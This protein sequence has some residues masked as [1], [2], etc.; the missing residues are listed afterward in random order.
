MIDLELLVY[1]LSIQTLSRSNRETKSNENISEVAIRAVCVLKSRRKLFL[2]PLN[3]RIIISS[4]LRLQRWWGFLPTWMEFLRDVDGN[5]WILFWE[6]LEILLRSFF[7]CCCEE[8]LLLK[9]LAGWKFRRLRETFPRKRN[10]SRQSERKLWTND[11]MRKFYDE[12]KW[13]LIWR[14]E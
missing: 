6:L 1:S 7:C 9:R 14:K 13:K 8:Y 2:S 4:R 5:I 3:I 10:T 11:I 12:D